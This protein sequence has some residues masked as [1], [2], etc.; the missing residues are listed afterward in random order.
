MFLFDQH[1]NLLRLPV[2]STGQPERLGPF[3]SSASCTKLTTDCIALLGIG[4]FL[5]LESDG[6]DRRDLDHTPQF[7]MMT[8][9]ILMCSILSQNRYLPR[10][11]VIDAE[12]NMDFRYTIDRRISCL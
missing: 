4:V 3:S 8:L 7:L 12:L 11:E 1:R 5:S 10:K 6:I 9:K 2:S